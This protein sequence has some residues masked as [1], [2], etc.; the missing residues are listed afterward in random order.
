[1]RALV[2][3]P[4]CRQVRE[5]NFDFGEALEGVREVIDG[6]AEFIPLATVWPRHAMF[7]DEDANLKQ[8]QGE[9]RLPGMVTFRGKAVVFGTDGRQEC[10]CTLPVSAAE[11]V[12]QWLPDISEVTA[13]P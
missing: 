2:I 3:D 10:D 9:F 7:V 8:T 4:V 1:M 12:I 11:E 5:E 6:W 13:R